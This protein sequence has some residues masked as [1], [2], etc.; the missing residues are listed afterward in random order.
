VHVE[1]SEG[2]AALRHD[3]NVAST[4]PPDGVPYAELKEIQ[5]TWALSERAARTACKRRKPSKPQDITQVEGELLLASDND[6]N[7]T[8]VSLSQ[9]TPQAPALW[10]PETGRAWPSS[11]PPTASNVDEILDD[12]GPVRYPS[13]PYLH[14]LDSQAMEP[15]PA[16]TRVE[17]KVNRKRTKSDPI[18][19]LPDFSTS[20]GL[21]D[22]SIRY[23]ICDR[24]FRISAGI[25]LQ[26][27]SAGPKLA[28]ICPVLFSPGY[29]Q[30]RGSICLES[31]DES[32]ILFKVIS[33][34][35]GFISTIAR[36]MVSIHDRSASE[37]LK[38]TFAHLSV[39]DPSTMSTP[40]EPSQDV[41][42]IDLIPTLK[43][44]LWI[45]AQKQLYD[46][47]AAQYL[48][49]LTPPNTETIASLAADD[50]LDEPSPP[51]TTTLPDT[52]NNA[53]SPWLCLL[54]EPS[55]QATLQNHSNDADSPWQCLLDDSEM[56]G[57]LDEQFSDDDLLLDNVHPDDDILG[58]Y[59]DEEVDL[60][61]EAMQGEYS[62]D[63]FDLFDELLRRT[64][65]D[66]EMDREML[67]QGPQSGTGDGMEMLDDGAE[68]ETSSM[69][70]ILSI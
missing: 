60:F 69:L 70:D 8:F 62:D 19:Q 67:S 42:E 25:K 6:E 46:P 66:L 45:L 50:M 26:D 31:L 49:P 24:T 37:T 53:G 33:Q 34:R 56:P 44:R 10:S 54:D 51:A 52:S 7:R 13:T 21:F 57:D 28:E 17:V 2:P 30:V 29:L 22:A 47:K 18:F 9:P 64:D 23:M 38:S 68:D 59:S 63:E 65:L 27:R 11:Q 43:A 35:N 61:D 16:Q 48:K 39:S 32:N 58:E 3:A 12:G 41:A 40:T 14:W 4:R 5:I 36:S 15:Q 1:T 20:L 55:S